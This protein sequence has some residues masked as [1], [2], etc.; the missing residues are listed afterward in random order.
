MIR[1]ASGQQSIRRNCS[2]NHV[3][4]PAS[5]SRAPTAT[6]DR[7]HRDRRRV[8][9][10]ARVIEKCAAEG[11]SLSRSVLCTFAMQRNGRRAGQE[12]IH[13]WAWR[14]QHA[15]VFYTA[16]DSRNRGSPG[17]VLGA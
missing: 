11:L 9:V 1:W 3:S 15:G 16:S 2:G 6:P 17:E 5:R 8:A 14:D 13:V 4:K 7:V 12:K 10:P